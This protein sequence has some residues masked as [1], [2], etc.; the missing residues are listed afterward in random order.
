MEIFRW[1]KL[2]NTIA[3]EQ[4][5]IQREVEK[6]NDKQIDKLYGFMITEVLDDI[7]GNMK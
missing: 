6:M 2:N 5:E 3:W 1:M 4:K 7:R